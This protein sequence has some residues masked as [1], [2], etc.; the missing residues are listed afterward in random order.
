MVTYQRRIVDDTLDAL[1]GGLPAVALEGAKGVGKTA[2]AVER[3]DDVVRF[4]VP[5]ELSA[6]SAAPFDLS[7]SGTLLLD[8]WHLYP[9]CWDQVRRAVDAGAPPGSFIL[10]GS[11][12]PVGT[13]IHSGAGRIVPLRMRPLSLAERG[14]ATPAVSLT[15]LLD[16]GREP[17][18]ARTDV[19]LA[20]YV[21]EIFRSGYPGI[22]N[23]PDGFRNRALDGYL[24]HTIEREFVEQGT[25]VRRPQTLAAWLRAYAAATATNTSYSNLLDAATAGL[26]NK[27]SRD[28]TTVYRDVLSRTFVLDPIDAWIPVFNPLKQ[29][30]QAPKHFLADP[31]L[32]ARLLELD[33]AAVAAGRDDVRLDPRGGSML[34]P[35]FEHLVAQSVL[36]YAQAS[37]ARVHHLRQHHG[38]HEVD[39]I[40][41]RG[42]RVVAMEV[43]LAADVDDTDVKH[44]VWLRAQLGEDLA[45][46][47]VI[48]T[49]TRAYRRPDGIA[50]V[51]AALLGV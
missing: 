49:G 13:R 29:L 16:G 27:P 37:D 21:D 15:N 14:T 26:P 51:P 42:R 18:R 5:A 20:D 10:A 44:L 12:A 36:V 43:K 30:A 7:A 9:E 45:D 6:F 25:A 4:D 28:T 39:L 17:V 19:V 35:L 2:S 8:E 47:L 48:T 24:T 40:V 22:R 34:G 32:A 31:A 23:Q 46:A 3:A 38:R 11:T 50:V 33:Q 1:T 41:E